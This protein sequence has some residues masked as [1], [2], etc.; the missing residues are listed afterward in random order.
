MIKQ[1]NYD[2]HR[3]E[4]VKISYTFDRR[5]T[6]IPWAGHDRHDQYSDIGRVLR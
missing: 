5:R 2:I 6:T 1:N 4:W 3:T